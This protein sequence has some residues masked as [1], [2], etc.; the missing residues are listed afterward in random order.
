MGLSEGFQD[1]EIFLHYP[2]G[3]KQSQWSLKR[4]AVPQRCTMG[5]NKE[6]QRLEGSLLWLGRWRRH[7][8]PGDAAPGPGTGEEVCSPLQPPEE[9]WACRHPSLS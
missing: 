5:Y 1:G 6:A 8:E 4:V 9:A 7:Y 2:G 3:D